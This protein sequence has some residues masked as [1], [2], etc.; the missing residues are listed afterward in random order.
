[1]LVAACLKALAHRFSDHL[2]IVD[3]STSNASRIC[4][5]YGTLTRKGD[6][7]PDRPHRY[8]CILEQPER[9]V[10]VPAAA[11]EALAAEVATA[12]P[13]SAEHRRAPSAGRRFRHAA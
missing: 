12:A 4:K 3:Q 1:M 11:L 8:S 10:P 13:K 9:A 6:A 5:L 2:V 7:T